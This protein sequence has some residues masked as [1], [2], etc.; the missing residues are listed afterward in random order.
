MGG[1]GGGVTKNTIY[2]RELPKRRWGEEAVGQFSDLRGRLGIK[3]GGGVF[4]TGLNSEDER[5]SRQWSCIM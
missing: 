3:E 2:R 1:E 4:D 5:V